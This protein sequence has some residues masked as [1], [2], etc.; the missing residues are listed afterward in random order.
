MSATALEYLAGSDVRPD[1]LDVLRE[2]GPLSRRHLTDRVP[3]SRRTVKRTLSAMD[4]RGWVRATDGGYE[5]TALGG[6]IH[7]AHE[8]FRERSRAAARLRP[9]L[10][11]VP[12]PTSGLD[13]EALSDATV[14]APEDDPAAAARM[15]TLRSDA[16]RLREYTPVLP[17]DGVRQLSRRVE[18]D[19]PTPEITLVVRTDAPPR[20]SPAYRERFETLTATSD[21]DVRRHPDGPGL[22]F[23]VADD[24]A[25]LCAVDDAGTPRFL[26]ES[27]SDA[28]VSWVDRRF[29]RCLAAAEPVTDR[30]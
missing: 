25:V 8:R 2:R 27:G 10:E 5:L 29:E 16:T 11:R 30:S 20:S 28:V 24:T 4:S 3:A 21:V 7:S 13:V 18:D 23:G 6:T 17:P 15:A 9:V 12:A 26:L 1:V 22:R 14:V 19:R